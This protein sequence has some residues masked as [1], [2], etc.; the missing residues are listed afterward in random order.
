MTQMLQWPE[1]YCFQKFLP[2]LTRWQLHH[3][4]EPARDSDPQLDMQLVYP[5]RIKKRRA[6]KGVASYEIIWRDLHNSFDGLIPDEQMKEF[7]GNY[8]NGSS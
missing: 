2:V 5:V 3:F 6:P 7:L 8:L 4:S 1:V